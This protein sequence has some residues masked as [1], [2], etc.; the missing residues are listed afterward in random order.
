VPLG[1][2]G[3]KATG[4]KE[5]NS[6]MASNKSIA[7]QKFALERQKRLPDAIKQ[8]LKVYIHVATM[9]CTS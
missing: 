6:Q 1:V 9:K 5:R 7:V 8:H 3:T 4:W 2:K